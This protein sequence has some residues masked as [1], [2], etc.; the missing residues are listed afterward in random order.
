MTEQIVLPEGQDF[1]KLNEVCK[2]VGVQP[3]ML[4]FWGKEIPEIVATTTDTGQRL[5]SREQVETILNVRKLL[6]EDGL[7]VP[8]ARKRINAKNQGAK[9]Q[10]AK[11][12]KTAPKEVMPESLEETPQKPVGEAVKAVATKTPEKKKTGTKKPIKANVETK[13]ETKV[14]KEQVDHVQPLLA[15]LKELRKEVSEIVAELRSQS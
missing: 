4:R 9:N 15:T 10:G 14:D 3:Y 1:F 11:R 8:G 7:S 5:Y 13:I 2:L 12:K 6:F